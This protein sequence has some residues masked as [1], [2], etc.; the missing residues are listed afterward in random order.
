LAKRQ[1]T[2]STTGFPLARE[3]E[4]EFLAKGGHGFRQGILAQDFLS[5][6]TGQGFHPHKKDD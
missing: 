5:E 1:P 6:I 4:F 3:I 2:I